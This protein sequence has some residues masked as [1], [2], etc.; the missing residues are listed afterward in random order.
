[1]TIQYRPN[2]TPKELETVSIDGNRHYCT[3]NGEKYVS[4]TT[5]L[6][7]FTAA[8]IQQWR[9]RVGEAEANRISSASASNGNRLHSSLELY[10]QDKDHTQLI[11][12]QEEQNQFDRIRN[13]LDEHLTET[14]Y[15]EVPLYSNRLKVAGRVDLIGLLDETPTIIDFKTSRKKKKKEWIQNY[16][17]QASFYAMSLYEMSG[18]EIK[19][20]CILITVNKGEDFQIYNEKVG[21]YMGSLYD[22][23]LKYRDF[24]E[25]QAA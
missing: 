23:I 1:M 12:S 22:K 13:Y 14:W 20:I 21:N 9:K 24:Q 11:E 25:Q 5:M 6:S 7:H 17:E 15:Q 4:I 18:I 10:L 3:P 19:D 8:S 2:F 16:F